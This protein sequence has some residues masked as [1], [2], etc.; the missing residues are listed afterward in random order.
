MPGAGAGPCEP[1]EQNH[2]WTLPNSSPL[3]GRG[4]TGGAEGNICAGADFV[5]SWEEDLTAPPEAAPQG[6]EDVEE[7]RTYDGAGRL[8]VL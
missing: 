6:V 7:E 1:Q 4:D 3:S 5:L 2:G 8:C